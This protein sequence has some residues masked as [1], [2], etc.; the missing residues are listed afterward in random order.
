MAA[1]YEY[2]SEGRSTLIVSGYV[3]MLTAVLLAARDGAGWVIWTSWA[4]VTFGLSHHLLVC[5]V[6][7]IRLDGARCTVFT[8]RRTRSFELSKIDHARLSDGRG[9]RL[10]CTL[11][12][13]GGATARLPSRCLPPPATLARVLRRHGVAIRIDRARAPPR[14]RTRI[15]ARNLSPNRP[16]ARTDQALQ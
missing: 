14:K 3:M 16:A 11:H 13:K 8:D 7:G 5:Q 1:P 9:C 12:F 4:L 10:D 2:R 15:F 6:A